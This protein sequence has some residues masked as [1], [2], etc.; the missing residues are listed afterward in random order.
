MNKTT[1][2]TC[3][4][5]R[6]GQLHEYNSKP[7]EQCDSCKGKARH[8]LA[9]HLYKKLFTGAQSAGSCLHLAPEKSLV[10]LLRA[11]FGDNYIPVD[12]NPERYQEIKPMKF[13][14]PE[15]FGRFSKD[16]FTAIIHNH[17]LEHLPGMYKEHVNKFIE[18][19]KPG[20]L[21]V[22]SIPGPYSTVLTQEGGEH[23]D[24][25]EERTRKFTRYDHFKIFGSDFIDHLQSIDTVDYIEDPTTN[26]V[27]ESLFVRPNKSPFFIL[28]KR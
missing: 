28:R 23:F 9:H 12:G 13:Y 4:I 22:F 10:P 7:Y 6:S 21:M 2:P 3:S 1:N 8:R 25:D 24:S 20:G 16:T 11:I 5:C 15:D 27:R 14:L 17:V 18:L 19:L 26:A